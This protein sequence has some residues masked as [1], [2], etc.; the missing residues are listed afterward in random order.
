MN[1]VATPPQP[2]SAVQERDSDV[3]GWW[4]WWT[5][6]MLMMHDHGV[7]MDAYAYTL[8]LEQCA[9]MSSYTASSPLPTLPS[10]RC[11]VALTRNSG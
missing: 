2:L 7:E 10:A 9:G 5:Q 8:V 11:S 4:R 6:L 3:D 1:F